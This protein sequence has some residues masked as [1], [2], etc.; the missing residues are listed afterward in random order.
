VAAVVSTVVV[1]A[2]RMRLETATTTP[3]S[4]VGADPR[5]SER[6]CVQSAQTVPLVRVW[7]A[8]RT[9]QSGGVP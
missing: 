3:P 5:T 6:P 1:K 9:E 8:R 2:A 7:K 4:S